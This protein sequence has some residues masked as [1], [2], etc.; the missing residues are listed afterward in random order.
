[1][2]TSAYRDGCPYPSKKKPGKV[3]GLK[4]FSKIERDEEDLV[5]PRA[6]Q[7]AAEIARPRHTQ[8]WLARVDLHQEGPKVPPVIAATSSGT[9]KADQWPVLTGPN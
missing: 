7:A 9:Y 6:L 5:L 8:P 2:A 1:M 4:L 3:P